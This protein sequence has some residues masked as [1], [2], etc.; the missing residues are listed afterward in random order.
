ME[1]LK[2]GFETRPFLFEQVGV[3]YHKRRSEKRTDNI[4]TS[5]GLNP[6]K[7]KP[8]TDASTEARELAELDYSQNDE[9]SESFY[10]DDNDESEEETDV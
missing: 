5:N 9:G 7:Y 4:L 6:S 10:S 3:N 2:K 1:L 8:N